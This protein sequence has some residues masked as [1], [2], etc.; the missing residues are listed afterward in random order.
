M[1]EKRWPAVGPLPFALQGTTNGIIYL[2]TVLGLYVK[3]Q[4]H[5]LDPTI[6][7]TPP[8]TVQIKRVVGFDSLDFTDFPYIEVGPLNGGIG[9]RTDVSAYGL[10]SS[11]FA[12]EQPRSSIPLQEIE[13]AIYADEPAVARRVVEV[14]PEGNYFTPN[15]PAPTALFGQQITILNNLLNMQVAGIAPSGFIVN[16]EGFFVFDNEGNFIQQG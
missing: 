3:Q 10:L 4:I 5:L 2:H 1:L 11:V 15:N 9:M 14:D 13:R 16:N 12:P 7:T 8:L 6:P